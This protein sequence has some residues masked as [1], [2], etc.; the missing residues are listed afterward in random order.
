MICDQKFK[1]FKTFESAPL[2]PCNLAEVL[3]IANSKA[4]LIA[5]A[6][7]NGR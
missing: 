7:M 1:L 6:S 3:Q 5:F 4:D 2:R